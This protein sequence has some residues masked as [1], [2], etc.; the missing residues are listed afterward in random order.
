MSFP[1]PGVPGGRYLNPDSWYCTMVW[2]ATLGLPLSLEGVGRR[3]GAG[4]AEAQ[5]GQRPGA[6]FL[7]AGKGQG[8]LHLSP[9]TR[10]R[11][12]RK[13]A[14]FK[15]YNLRDVETEMSIQQKLSRFPVSQEEWEELPP[16]P[17]ASTTG[18]FCWTAPWLAQAIRCDERFKR[19]HLEQAPLGHWAGEPQQPRPAQSVAGGK[20]R[21]SRIP[22]QSIRAGASVPCGGRGGAGPIPAAGAGQEQCQKIHRHGGGGLPG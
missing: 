9:P 16:R 20:G 17:S 8:W 11:G 14:A 21:G 22:L 12:R 2:S 7:H 3:A 13:W 4:E 18:A 10:R 6:L 5:G 1:V 15:A 19:T